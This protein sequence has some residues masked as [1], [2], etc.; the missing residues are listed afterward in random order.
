MPRLERDGD[1]FVLRL[2]PDD[3]N[4]FSLDWLDAV[5]AA[6]DEAEAADSPRALVT[7][8][9]GKFWSNGL[10]VD[11]IAANGDRVGWYIGRVNA[12]LARTLVSPVVT[13]AAVN[14]HAFGAGAIW[15]LAHDFRVMRA[16]RGYFCLPE[17]DLGLPFTPVM[18]AL[19]TGRLTPQAA[20]E[21][22]TTGRRYGG[23]R[24]LVAGIVDQVADADRVLGASVEFARPLTG[25]STPVRGKIKETMYAAVV[26]ALDEPGLGVQRLD[27]ARELLGEDAALDAELGR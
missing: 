14:G 4:R 16:D 21:A 20:H 11:W 9:S 23:E 13:V 22:M 24:A 2:E 15:S 7:A 3:E 12:L 1:V 6:L 26:A 5:E 17:V 10:D 27:F 19:V 8:G 25:K 18:S